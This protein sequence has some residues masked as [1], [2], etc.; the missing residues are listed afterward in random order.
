[1]AIILPDYKVV[2][3]HVP[4]TGGLWIENFFRQN[5]KATMIANRHSHIR[6]IG[7]LAYDNSWKKFCFLREPA[8][9]YK[10]YWQMKMGETPVFNVQGS[11]YNGTQAHWFPLGIGHDRGGV[12]ALHHPTWD[13]DPYC[14]SNDLNEF[15]ENCMKLGGFLNRLYQNFV[16]WGGARCNYVGDF[17]N[18]IPDLREFLDEIKFPYTEESLK[19]E[20]YNPS[21]E[22]QELLPWLRDSVNEMEDFYFKVKKGWH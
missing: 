7:R 9:W 15:V 6:M 4:K 17:K 13:I 21:V 5:A 1:M 14:G 8:G 3:L 12:H 2:F 19:R 18:L 16:G 10:S 11:G 20:K 22:R